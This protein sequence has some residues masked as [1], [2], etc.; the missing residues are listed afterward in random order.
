MPRGVLY[1]YITC[2]DTTIF[3]NFNYL[4]GFFQK[5]VSPRQ[6]YPYCDFRGGLYRRLYRI[7]WID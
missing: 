5:K 1:G 2:K 6:K 3:Y 4:R 7:K